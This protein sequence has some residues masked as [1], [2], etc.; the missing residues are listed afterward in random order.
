MTAFRDF[1]FVCGVY[2]CLAVLRVVGIR[3]SDLI[4]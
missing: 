3:P 1:A 2:A 4:E